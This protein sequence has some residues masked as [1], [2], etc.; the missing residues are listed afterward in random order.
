MQEVSYHFCF[1][2]LLQHGRAGVAGR[3]AQPAPVGDGSE[4]R[5]LHGLGEPIERRATHAPCQPSSA[6]ASDGC[7][8]AATTQSPYHAGEPSINYIF[9]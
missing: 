6:S 8:R 3:A 9:L 7:T 4:L 2:V 1:Q 5:A